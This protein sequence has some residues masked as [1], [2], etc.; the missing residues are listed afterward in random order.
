MLE[1]ER[2]LFREWRPE[3]WLTF[4]TIATDPDVVRY[5]STGQPWPDDRIQR[6]VNRQ[7]ENLSTK[8]FCLWQL[9]LI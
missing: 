2:L 3:D 8:G 1:T 4:R 6:F 9:I 5:I 7:I